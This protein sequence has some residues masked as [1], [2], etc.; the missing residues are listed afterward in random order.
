MDVLISTYRY[1]I[2]GIFDVFHGLIFCW[3][4]TKRRCFK[5][6][7]LKAIRDNPEKSRNLISAAHGSAIESR[8]HEYDDL[9]H[10]TTAVGY[11]R[12]EK[13]AWRPETNRGI[14]I[15]HG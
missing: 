1:P 10:A 8:V 6:S 14:L 2:L 12:D 13:D 4:G 3:W 9:D 7:Y 15:R 5:H 11:G